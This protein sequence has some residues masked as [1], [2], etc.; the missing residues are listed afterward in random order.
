MRVLLI[1]FS[2]FTAFV[3]MANM[4]PD[5]DT[6]TESQAYYDCM[7][8]PTMKFQADMKRAEL[9]SNLDSRRIQHILC[10]G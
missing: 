8:D 9:K 3:V 1:C 10:G 4:L 2:L 5:T 7:K 6:S